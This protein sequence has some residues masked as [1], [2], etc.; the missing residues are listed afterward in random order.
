MIIYFKKLHPEAV[1][2]TRLTSR[3]AGLDLYAHVLNE[4]GRPGSAIVP[5]RTTRPIATGVSILIPSVNT[6]PPINFY[7]QVCSRSGMATKSLFVTNAPGIIDPDY[8]G[9]IIVLLYNG[10]NEVH[11]VKHGDRVAQVIV[12]STPVYDVRWLEDEL[13]KT[14]RGARGFGSSGR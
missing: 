10:G 3:S 5:P 1:I 12:T 14:E 8:T 4:Q 7:A 6:T 9:E 13:P 2:P 11:Y